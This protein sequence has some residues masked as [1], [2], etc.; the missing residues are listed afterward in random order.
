MELEL[1]VTLVLPPELAQA[2]EAQ[3]MQLRRALRAL[4][5]SAV[6]LGLA[7]ARERRPY[8]RMPALERV[9]VR[10]QPLPAAPTQAPQQP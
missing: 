8:Q 1:C 5:E 2:P 4:V 7:K 10:E 6:V 9:A 3:A